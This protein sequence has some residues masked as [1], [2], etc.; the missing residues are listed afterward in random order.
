VFVR[1]LYW[2]VLDDVSGGTSRNIVSWYLHSPEVLLRTDT[3][4][5]TLGEKGLLIQPAGGMLPAR[6]GVGWAASTLVTDPGE[7]ELINWVAF[8]QIADSA[9]GTQCAVLL[10]PYAHGVPPAFARTVAPG[11]FVV[12]RGDTVD[13]LALGG[14]TADGGELVTDARF[15]FVRTVGGTVRHAEASGGTSVRFRGVSVWQ[16][17]SG[18]HQVQ[19]E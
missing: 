5:V 16:S 13:H 8:D 7:T 2:F 1:P 18:P 12:T 3:A 19:G 10:Y 6:E 9:A 14:S 11:H 17:A 15:A 4:Y